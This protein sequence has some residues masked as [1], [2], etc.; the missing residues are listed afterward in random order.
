MIQLS[1]NAQVSLNPC[2]RKTGVWVTTTPSEKTTV[3]ATKS[4][5]KYHRDGCRHLGVTKIPLTL[6]EAVR[7]GYGSMCHVR[8]A[9]VERS[10]TP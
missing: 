1:L 6:G 7:L 3:F 4:G 2:P 8:A 9:R 10:I 5:T